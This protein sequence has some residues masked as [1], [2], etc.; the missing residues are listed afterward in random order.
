MQYGDANMTEEII[1]INAWGKYFTELVRSSKA[2]N[3]T[4]VD[5]LY[6]KFQASC[7]NCGTQYTKEALSKLYL[8][9]PDSMF[10]TVA[11]VGDSKEGTDISA[12]RC[13]NCGHSKM[14][15]VKQG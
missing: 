9:G 11:I 10:G 14:R 15:I 13:P 4:D 8:F 2:I 12:G 1:P 7:A 6:S 5:A 3:T